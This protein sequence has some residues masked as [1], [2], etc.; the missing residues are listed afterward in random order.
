MKKF[1]KEIGI[2]LGDLWLNN[3]DYLTKFKKMGINHLELLSFHLQWLQ[4]K[5][6]LVSFLKKL[7]GF[8]LTV[9]LPWGSCYGE[10]TDTNK[11]LL[12]FKK[13]LRI[14]QI[15][16]ESNEST[17]PVI[18]HSLNLPDINKSRE[19]TIQLIDKINS[20]IKK[21]KYDLVI[22]LEN[23][24]W[25]R[26]RYGRGLEE[27]Y[28]MMKGTKGIDGICLDLGHF[29]VGRDIDVEVISQL[30]IEKFIEV[31]L[32]GGKNPDEHGPISSCKNI[33]NAAEF[34][35]RNKYHGPFV[36]EYSPPIFEKLRIEP[37]KTLKKDVASLKKI[38][39]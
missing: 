30:F 13:H 1:S 33:L 5:N 29:L 23:T 31:H 7:H 16:A 39:S 25:T 26:N 19:K 10:G 27:V 4:N 11:I 32:H 6:S 17:T 9:H 24:V 15:I 36:F 38:L 22:G 37:F 14:A 8:N 21:E 12:H 3:D 18:I 35:V 20:T 2:S 28:D 34:L